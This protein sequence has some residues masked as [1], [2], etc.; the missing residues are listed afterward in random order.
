MMED[1]VEECDPWEKGEKETKVYNYNKKNKETMQLQHE[2]K[3]NKTKVL[4]LLDKRR[5]SFKWTLLNK[6]LGVRNFL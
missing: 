2:K 4:E 5:F 1:A 6:K 3:N